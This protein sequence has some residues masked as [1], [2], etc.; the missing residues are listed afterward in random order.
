MPCYAVFAR[1]NRG[2]ATYILMQKP[3]FSFQYWTKDLPAGLVVFLV[4]V[5]LCLGIA[6]A[7][8]APLYAGMIAGMVGGIVASGISNSALSVSG[9]AA[10]LAAIVAISIQ[11]LGAFPTFL[12]AVVLAGVLQIGFGLIRAGILANYI[13]SSVIKG[14]LTAIGILIILKQIPHAF[15][16]DADSEGD[17]EFFQ[18]DGETTLG[19]LI[20][21][22]AH[23]DVSAIS[24]ALVSMAI[25]LLA[26][27]PLVK[28][29]TGAI[30]GALIAV[31]ICTVVNTLFVSL[32]SSLAVST[33]HLVKLPVPATFS[34]FL[35]GFTFP[36]FS[37]IANKQV[38]IVAITLAVVA[39]IETLLCIEAIDKID[40]HKRLTSTNR[41]LFAQGAANIVSGLIGG[42]PITSVIVRSSAN[43]NAGGETR[44]SAIIH[45]ILLLI[46][47][48]TIPSLLNKIP[49]A[50]LAAILLL[51]G[52]KLANISIFKEMFGRGKYQFVPFIATVLGIVF[53]DLLVGI[54]I[55]VAVSVLA[56]LRE[57]MK[58][59]YSF[60]TADYQEGK[61]ITIQ[62][63]EEVSFLNKVA[64][65]ESLDEIPDG[66]TVVI[67]ASNSKYIDFDVLEILRD[68]ATTNAP[69]N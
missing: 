35:N 44:L 30:P 46:C 40:P 28:K 7:S 39:S 52:Y 49:L 36:D 2:I 41:E 15:G 9:P 18:T 22:L 60:K 51:T 11:Q 6:L 17:F 1:K 47:A 4:A 20:S 16:Y 8:G 38:Y 13:P 50:S 54:G 48:A 45:G 55:G 56:V 5:P 67:D 24:F 10:G 58:T 69:Q 21:T 68:F 59:A 65:R 31:T 53:T 32:D 12:L 14:L 19:A 26:E 64:I 57:N 29:Y 33:E 27:R 42:L 34:D 43:V 23:I 25:I 66:S 63:A 37:Q 62:L 3:T 61:V